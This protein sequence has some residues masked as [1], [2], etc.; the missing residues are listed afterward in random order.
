MPCA[1]TSGRHR[2]RRDTKEV[3]NRGAGLKRGGSLS[4]GLFDCCQVI[5]RPHSRKSTTAAST[6]APIMPINGIRRA[7]TGSSSS[8][9]TTG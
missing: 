5:Q 2:Q 4:T 6:A 8:I 1:A 7:G 3:R 9:A